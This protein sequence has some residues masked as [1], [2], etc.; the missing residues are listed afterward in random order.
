MVVYTKNKMEPIKEIIFKVMITFPELLEVRIEE[1][2][3]TRGTNF[4]VLEIINDE[5]PFCVIK[6]DKFEYSDISDDII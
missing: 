3:N 5:V 4:K 2:N 6:A 1:Y